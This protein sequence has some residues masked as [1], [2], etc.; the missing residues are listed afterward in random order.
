MKITSLLS[1]FVS[2]HLYAFPAIFGIFLFMHPADAAVLTKCGKFASVIVGADSNP[3]RVHNN[4]WNGLNKSQCIQVNDASGEFRIVSSSHNHSVHGAPASYAFIN[5]GCH[6]GTCTNAEGETPRQIGEITEAKSSW[7]TTQ[8]DA[9]VY[10]VAYDIWFHRNSM[11]LGQPDGAELMIWLA[12]KGDIQPIG[13]LQ[14]KAV[15]I[16]GATWDVWAGSNGANAVITYVRTNSINSVSDL[17]IKSFITDGAAKGY[18]QNDWYLIS[19]GAG[20]E[21]WKGG[22]GLASNSFSFQMKVANEGDDET[23]KQVPAIPGNIHAMAP[24]KNAYF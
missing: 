7:N 15:S 3:Y 21:I 11:A 2:L 6:W 19:I 13:S 16:D 4:I 23:A 22:N 24:Q 10:N 5:K 8:T 12:Y 9:G 1:K 18:L 14:E 20:F 17:D